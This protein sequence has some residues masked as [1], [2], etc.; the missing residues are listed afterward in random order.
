MRKISTVGQAYVQITN[1]SF[2][3][4]SIYL[5]DDDHDANAP[6]RRIRPLA[7]LAIGLRG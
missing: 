4:N 2:Y 1:C 3:E 6:T 5:E 7:A